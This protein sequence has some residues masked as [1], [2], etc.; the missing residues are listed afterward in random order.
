VESGG[1]LV[2]IT[3]VDPATTPDSSDKPENLP[4]GLLDLQIKTHDVGG[5]IKV[6]FYLESQAG[7]GEKW[8]KYRNSTGTWEDFSAYAS[9]NAT[10][11]QVTLTLVDGGAGD[12]DNAANGWIVDPSGLGETS[13]TTPTAGSEGGGGGGGGCFIATAEDG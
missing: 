12:D 9:S 5:T 2:S 4:Y 8:F 3:V 11:D 7:N 6:I 1:D 10:K 13:T